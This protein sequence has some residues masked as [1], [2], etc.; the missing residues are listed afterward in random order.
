MTVLPTTRRPGTHSDEFP[1]PAEDPGQPRLLQVGIAAGVQTSTCVV[2]AA[3]RPLFDRFP[4]GGQVDDD[5]VDQGMRGRR[6][7][8]FDQQSQGHRVGGYMVPG[9]RRRDSDSVRRVLGRQCAIEDECAAAYLDSSGSAL[10]VQVVV[11]HAL[12]PGS[13]VNQGAPKGF[14]KVLQHTVAPSAVGATGLVRC[15]TI[16][17]GRLRVRNS[18]RSVDSDGVHAKYRCAPN[19]VG[20]RP[21]LGRTIP[22]RMQLWRL[23]RGC[24]RATVGARQWRALPAVVGNVPR[25]NSARLQT[26]G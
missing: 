11:H 1:A 22:T 14:E 2:R 7:R 12:H 13:L 26:F 19:C 3:Q 4:A 17:T 9:N 5:R 15:R 21:V 18:L 10:C 16:V 8:I 24:N 6:I 25:K 20:Q 23:V